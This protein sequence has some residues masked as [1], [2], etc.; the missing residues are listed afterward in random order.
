MARPLF[1]AA[2]ALA[3]C[4]FFENYSKRSAA[5]ERF[6]Q[7]Q[8]KMRAERFERALALFE[9]SAELFA[10]GEDHAGAALA[11]AAAGSAAGELER[12]ERVLEL[13]GRA[14][15]HYKVT[16]HR[17][18]D[19]VGFVHLDIASSLSALDRSEEAIGAFDAARAVLEATRGHRDAVLVW[20]HGG[21][22]YC[23]TDLG[24]LDAADASSSRA[25]DLAENGVHVD[26]VAR[27]AGR[28]VRATF[29]NLA[30]RYAEAEQVA[31]RAL[32]ETASPEPAP[33]V[34][35]ARN[36]LGYSLLYRD[37]PAEALAEF[38]SGRR[39]LTERFG[40][41]HEQTATLLDSVGEARRELGDPAAALELHERALS[42]RERGG[43]K[44]AVGDA[45]IVD[46]IGHARLDLG[47]PAEA[48]ADFTRAAGTIRRAHGDE[49]H[50]LGREHQHLAEARF[51]AGDAAAACADLERAISIR[52]ATLGED[53]P[54]TKES[55]RWKARCAGE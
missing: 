25:L 35:S 45:W 37:R 31:R 55:L 9:E 42:I 11:Y 12:H 17:E 26:A 33:C 16:G 1:A 23:Q 51:A 53:H 40:P 24:R 46:N 49:H 28:V 2:L 6:E 50:A 10:A 39:L 34:A 5:E 4:G 43:V 38:E 36:Q 3:G 21:K 19:W 13:S 15:D 47:R 18:T 52:E 48:I 8:A 27:C 54:L 29:L 41:E 20:A 7:A 32:A 30:G 22:T 44:D 14:L